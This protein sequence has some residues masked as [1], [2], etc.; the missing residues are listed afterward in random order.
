MSED[1]DPVLSDASVIFGPTIL[2]ML[3]LNSQSLVFLPQPTEY[4]EELQ[5][6]VTILYNQSVCLSVSLLLSPPFLSDSISKYSRDWN[7]QSSCLCPSSASHRPDVVTTPP[8]SKGKEISK[9]RLYL[10]ISVS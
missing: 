9:M 2:P 10:G 3:L 8:S 5:V 6:H 4:L 1:I 7:Q